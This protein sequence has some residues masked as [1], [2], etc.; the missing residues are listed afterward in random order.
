MKHKVPVPEIETL[1]SLI[2]PA[3]DALP[4]PDPERMRAIRDG[5]NLAFV[6]TGSQKTVNRLP[7]WV[8]LLITGG[9]ATAGWWAAELI[10]EGTGNADQENYPEIETI[11]P[12]PRMQGE[13]RSS[14]PV[15]PANRPPDESPLIYQREGN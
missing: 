3:C 10:H 4:G 12:A 6:R 9:L 2:A 14:K 8:V 1:E 7:W 13:H 15:D 11:R 5:M